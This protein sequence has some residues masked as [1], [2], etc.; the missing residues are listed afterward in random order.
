MAA[1]RDTAS[2]LDKL[3]AKPWSSPDFAAALVSS[4]DPAALVA[5]VQRCFE[6]GKL[7]HGNRLRV[8]LALLG[9]SREERQARP[10]LDPVLLKLLD[11][12]DKH[13]RD[14]WVAM[15]SGL[16]RRNIEPEA[17]PRKQ[18]F[19]AVAAAA[20]AALGSESSGGG[21]DGGDPYYLPLELAM[22]D[23]SLVQL[24]I[25]HFANA[26][27]TPLDS[28]EIKGSAKERAK[29]DLP[30]LRVASRGNAASDGSVAGDRKRPRDLEANKAGPNGNKRMAMVTAEAA[31]SSAAAPAASSWSQAIPQAVSVSERVRGV[32]GEHLNLLTA[33]ACAAIERLLASADA[34]AAAGANSDGGVGAEASVKLKVHEEVVVDASGRRVKESIYVHLDFAARVWKKTRKKKGLS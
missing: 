17:T 33:E 8:L 6:G 28:N 27:F 31:S 34:A 15:V 25:N 7:D 3:L 5:D 18:P 9:V 11:W 23:P 19:G 22:L 32:V 2:W 21:G 26:H 1:S 10:G 4:E 30:P 20:L 13:D 29:W 16:V 12:V 24:D 14:E